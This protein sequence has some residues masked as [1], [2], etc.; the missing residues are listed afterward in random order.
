M[1][2]TA[3][4]SGIGR[5]SKMRAMHRSGAGRGMSFSFLRGERRRQRG[6]PLLLLSRLT[7]DSSLDFFIPAYYR[8]SEAFHLFHL[9][10]ALKEQQINTRIF[11][12][13][14]ALRHTFGRS[15]ETGA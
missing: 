14:D 9:R 2:S 5:R 4:I 8:F 15:D 13:R 6:Y 7:A 1:T 12:L 10:A 3:T 11:K